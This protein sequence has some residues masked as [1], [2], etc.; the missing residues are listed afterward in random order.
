MREELS[1]LWS[2]STD[3]SEQLLMRLKDWCHRAEM[4]GIEALA[5]FSFTLKRYA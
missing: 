4:S 5:T 1:A 3:S 2:R